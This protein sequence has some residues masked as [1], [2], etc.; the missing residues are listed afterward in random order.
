MAPR[1]VI[2]RNGRGAH[3]NRRE[4]PFRI[5]RERR[6]APRA[7]GATARCDIAIRIRA[8]SAAV[9]LR[10]PVAHRVAPPS[11]DPVSGGVIG[12]RV[13]GLRY[14]TGLGPTRDSV[15]RI[16]APRWL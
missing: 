13:R 7:V 16:R 10:D 2:E 15:V 8:V 12:E 11:V 3:D 6:S 9:E 4:C 5:P 1:V 14:P